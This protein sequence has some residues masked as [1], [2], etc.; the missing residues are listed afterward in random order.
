V[1]EENNA[2]YSLKPNLHPVKNKKQTKAVT[3][4]EPFEICR[5]HK[6]HSIY[7][8]KAMQQFTAPK[9]SFIT[10]ATVSQLLL[11]YSAYIAETPL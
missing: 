5:L 2:K 8:Y 4:Q 3:L 1:V 7:T 11:V 6:I 10:R 9:T